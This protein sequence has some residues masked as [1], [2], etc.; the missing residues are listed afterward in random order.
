MDVQR[1]GDVLLAADYETLADKEIPGSQAQNLN[2]FRLKKMNG[3][4]VKGVNVVPLIVAGAAHI[5]RVL[6]V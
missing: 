4:S 6:L 3:A 2:D 5:A 1:S